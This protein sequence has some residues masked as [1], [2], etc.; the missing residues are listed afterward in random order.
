MYKDGSRDGPVETITPLAQDL[1]LTPDT[2]VS[3]D[4][5]KGAARAARGWEGPGN[6]LVCW[7]HGVLRKIVKELGVEDKMVRYAIS[8]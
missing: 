3:R 4:D 5:A 6:V 7:E 2:S 8:S 1:G